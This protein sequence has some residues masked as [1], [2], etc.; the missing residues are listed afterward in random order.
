[1]AGDG[2]GGQ[3]RAA[4]PDLNCVDVTAVWRFDYGSGGENK[5]KIGPWQGDGNKTAATDKAFSAVASD[6]GKFRFFLKLFGQFI[7]I[8]DFEAEHFLGAEADLMRLG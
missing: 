4:T 3:T 7:V 5:T 6:V 2:T 1:M 8:A